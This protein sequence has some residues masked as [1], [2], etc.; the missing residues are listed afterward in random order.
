M[1]AKSSAF[2]NGLFIVERNRWNIGWAVYARGAGRP[3][4]RARLS[5]ISDVPRYDHCGA[6]QKRMFADKL[7]CEGKIRLF[8]LSFTRLLT[9]AGG[10]R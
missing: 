8:V 6:S 5:L 4:S 2:C 9:S 10:A 3:L 1:H 7:F